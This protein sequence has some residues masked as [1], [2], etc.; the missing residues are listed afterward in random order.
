M[1]NCKVLG[2]YDSHFIYIPM[3]L[4]T[5]L[6]VNR[7]HELKQIIQVCK[8]VCFV[9]LRLS[10]MNEILFTM[11]AV[12]V[13]MEI[14]H[15][16]VTLQSVQ[17]I[18]VQLCPCW[19]HSVEQLYY[20]VLHHAVVDLYHAVLSFYNPAAFI[21]NNTYETGHITWQWSSGMSKETPT[22]NPWSWYT[23]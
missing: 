13:S 18:H 20:N 7:K 23:I 2:N 17:S 1:F 3:W 12:R 4:L 19:G 22:D 5:L 15:C 11:S 14:Q 8:F 16:D 10:Q 21:H 6:T 9:T